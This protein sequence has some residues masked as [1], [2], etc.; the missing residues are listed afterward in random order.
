MSGGTSAVGTP[1]PSVREADCASCN[2]T[3][4]CAR[5]A[6][7]E[8][9]RCD[10]MARI[11]HPH[12]GLTDELAK[13]LDEGRL[14]CPHCG[15]KA[16]P[17]KLY[18]ATAISG[19]PLGALTGGSPERHSRFSLAVAICA[20]CGK[21]SVFVRKW[22]YD[23][24]GHGDP[25]EVTAWHRRLYPMGRAAKAFPNATESHVKAYREACAVLELS[26]SASACMSRRCLQGVLLE[27]GY[28]QKDLAKQIDAL[29]AETD[30]KKVLPAG[31]HDA[32]D[33][34]RSFGNFGAHPITDVTTLQIIEVDEGEADWCIEVA[35][36]LM[37]HY[38]ERPAK[39]KA[40]LAAAN[41][42]LQSGGKPPL[43]SR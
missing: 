9:I 31:L 11:P 1:A 34:I 18:G 41:E 4:R 21:E 12:D 43:K 22:G 13:F 42:K 3:T 37:K 19:D 5:V 16:K 28:T 24:S 7:S 8:T 29:L 15:Q 38:Y 23:R 25:E 14:I 39:L 20:A 30:P 36:E 2:P 17:E 33:V 26:P 40:K 27:Q 35:E 10:E 6:E 32:V